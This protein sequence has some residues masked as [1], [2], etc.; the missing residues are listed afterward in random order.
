MAERV[1][2]LAAAQLIDLCGL[3]GVRRGSVG[4]WRRQPLVFVNLG[5][6]QG[7]DFLDLAEEVQQA[8]LQRFGVALQMEPRVLGES[9]TQS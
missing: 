4:V 9:R 3:K 6:A 5:R 7:Q 8:V 1:V 2:K